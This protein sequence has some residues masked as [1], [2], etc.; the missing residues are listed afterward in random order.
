MLNIELINKKMDE[1]TA[2]FEVILIVA[3]DLKHGF[4]K[5][6]DKFEAFNYKGDDILI[7]LES[8]RAYIAIKELSFEKMRNT[9]FQT[10]NALKNYNISSFKIASYL[11]GCT[12]RTYMAMAE[13]IIF[14]AYEFNKYKSDKKKYSLNKI[15]ISTE[16]YSGK[17]IKLEKAQNGLKYGKIMANATNYAKDG[18]NE[19]PEIY[20]PEKMANE[21]EILAAA[22]DSVSCKVYDEEFLKEQNMNAFLA[23]N[24]SSANEPRLIHMTYKPKSE[25]KK[26]IIFVGKGLTYDSGGLS[27][28]PSDYMLTMKCDKSGALAAMGII[29]GA[30]ELELGFEIHA[31]IGATENMIGGN[32]YKPDDVLISRSGTTIE[33]RNTD[34]EGRLVLADCLSY[35]QDFAPDI[36]IDIATLTGACAV[37][38]GEYTTGLL[39]NSAELKEKF[40]NLSK[41]S[42]EFLINLEFNDHL[43]E[44]I[45]SN[46][47][48]VSNTSSSRYGGTLTAGLFLDKFIKDENKDKWL[49]LDIAGPAY[50]EKA[51]GH[52]CFGATGAGVRASLYF[53]KALEK[54]I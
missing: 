14:G 52:N 11:C 25:S 31:I 41:P 17:E 47:A 30:A 18:V 43:K 8:K 53:L 2:D 21:A 23:V 48:D 46:I 19:I 12:T 54:E 16:E 40:K 49:H 37:G 9:M 29:K 51:W 28:K 27:L 42:G 36:L 15:F 5:D 4:I 20:T 50:L 22:Y 1:I 35:A 7:L 3:N 13:G 10:Y 24:R 45:K 34:A 38:L 44:L 32:S 39:G 26:R 33:V 6:S